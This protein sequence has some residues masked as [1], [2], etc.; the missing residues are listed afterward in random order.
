[1]K[2]PP[3]FWHVWKK[4]IPARIRFYDTGR[5]YKHLHIA[6]WRISLSWAV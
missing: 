4:P 5:G 6:F 3:F 2:K 1:M